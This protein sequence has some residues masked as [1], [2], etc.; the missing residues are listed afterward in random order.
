MA[1][2]GSVDFNITRDNIIKYAL[3]NIGAIAQGDTPTS[4]QVTDA[5]VYLNLIVKAW[6]AAGMPLWALKEGYI[7]PVSDTNTITLGPSGGHATLSYVHTQL[8]GDEA[9]GQ[10]A[11]TVDS[12]T[13]ISASDVIGIELDDGSI[14]WTTVSGAPSGTTVTVADALTGDA[15]EDN[16]VYV[17]TSKI[18][19]PLKILEASFYNE[20]SQTDTPVEVL[21]HNEWFELSNKETEGQPIQLT[22]LPNLER[23][24]AYV[25]PRF[26]NGDGV[27]KIWFHRP[28]EDFDSATDNPD[29]PQEFYMALVWALSWAIA[30]SYGVPLEE[31]KMMLQ[32]AE[33]LK[34]EALSFVMEEGSM[35]LQPSNGNG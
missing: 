19:R 20:D 29:F 34:M 2:S 31:R 16:H 11:L 26:Q 7:L 35:Y 23:G 22:Y 5:A 21:T 10:T 28:Y 25:W 33:K 6:H 9:T 13:G 17:Y 14:Q 32:E 24:T 4:T 12:I 8:G 27:I 3:L 30:P 1:T 18:Q 15:A